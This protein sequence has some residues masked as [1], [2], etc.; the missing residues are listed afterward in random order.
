MSLL[1]DIRCANVAAKNP[2]GADLLFDFNEL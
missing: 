1:R 2:R